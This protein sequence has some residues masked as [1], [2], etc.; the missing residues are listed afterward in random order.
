[1]NFL[2]HDFEILAKK[3]LEKNK[4]TDFKYIE[5]GIDGAAFDINCNRVLKITSSF[6]EVFYSIKLL[7][8]KNTQIADIY[9]VD[10]IND[11]GFITQEKIDCTSELFK[12]KRDHFSFIE[13]IL[14]YHDLYIHNLNEDIIDKYFDK[15]EDIK[16][17]KEI[18]SAINEYQ[19][20]TKLI[21]QDLWHGNFGLKNNIISLFDQKGF[22]NDIDSEK[23]KQLLYPK[24]KKNIKPN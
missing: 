21:P 14:S 24:N 17:A 16:I 19:N 3:Y 6:S 12:K 9:K 13:D 22:D 23:I 7:N 10:F 4:I 1:M 20:T 2:D 11:Y 18:L 5:S 8:K 15:N